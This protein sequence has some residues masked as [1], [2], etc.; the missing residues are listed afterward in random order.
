MDA[1]GRRRLGE[2]AR[3]RYVER[4]D[5]RRWSAAMLGLFHRGFARPKAEPALTGNV[6]S[7]VV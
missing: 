7:R 2:N 5:Y 4:Y 3:Q 6:A 1:D